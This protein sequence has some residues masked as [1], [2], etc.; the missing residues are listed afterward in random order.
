MSRTNSILFRRDRTWLMAIAMI[1]ALVS[2]SLASLLMQVEQAYAAAPTG[3]TSQTY[4]DTDN[5]GIIDQVDVVINGGEALTTCDVAD[6]EIPTDWTY[7]GN[8]I[9]GSL[10]ATGHSCVL[11]TATVTL[12]ITGANADTTG[13]STA[14]TIAYDNDDADASIVNASGTLGTVGAANITDGAAPIITA[15]VLSSASNRNRVSFTYSENMTIVNGAST[16]TKGDTDT[17][18]TVDGFGTF[19]TTGDVTVNTGLNTVGGNG[20]STLYVD[21]ADQAAGYMNTASTT[22]P[23]GVFSESA[24]ASIVD[25]VGLQVNTSGADPTAS[26]GGSWD[27]TKP[28]LT[29]ITV[30]DAAGNNGKIDRAVVVFDS[31][32]R[33]ANI[34]AADATLSS[35][36]GTTTV[37]FDTGTANDATA[38]FNRTADDAAVDTA[39]GTESDFDYSAA[40]TKITDLAGN[41]LDTSVDGAIALADIAET[42]GASPI[43]TAVALSSASNRNRLSFTYSENMTVANGASTATK[44]DLDSA[45][46]VRGFG[47]FGT[48]ND[49]TVTAGLNTVGGNGTSTITIDLA[50]QAGG[51]MDSTSTTEPSGNFTPAASVDVTDGTNQVNPSAAV[52][53]PSGGSSWDLTKPAL[54]S[55]TFSDAAGNNGQIDQAVIVFDSAVRDA[56]ITNGDATLGSTG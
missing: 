3:F 45:G 27:L 23:S 10:A 40:T 50:D 56:N 29:S 55:I 15:V 25:G 47:S 7:V 8:D 33:D 54:T 38:T 52:V 9:G 44:G 28:A 1:V 18:G 53:A 31:S 2:V 5:D 51:Y 4:Y 12:I 11:G 34:T 17:A 39:I 21:L 37:T 13:H 49:V 16:G 48:A 42:D 24:S 6:A 19:A 36:A 30:S 43:L 26:G 32:V 41:L 35:T 46:L 14:P 20:T 22:E